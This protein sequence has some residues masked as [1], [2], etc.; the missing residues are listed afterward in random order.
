VEALLE[1]AGLSTRFRTFDG[2]VRAV[3]DVSFSLAQGEVLALVGESGCG[4]SVTAR[5]VMG[6]YK[7]SRTVQEG[8]IRFRGRELMGLPEAERIKYRGKEMS[9]IFQEPMAAFDPLATVGEQMV[10]ARLAHVLGSDKAS[11]AGHAAK[12]EA[13]ALAVEALRSVGIPDPGMRIDE[14]PHRLSGGMLQRVLIATALMNEPCL[15]IADEPT[16]ALD[17]TIQAQVL[18]LI[19]DL[20]EKNGMAVLFITHDLGVVAEVADRV[21]VM[22]SGSIVEKASVRELFS[23]DGGPLHPYAQGLLE[24][25]VRRDRKG[26]ELPSIPGSVPRP[27][28]LPPGCRFAP[29]CPKAGPRCGREVPKLAAVG[30]ETQSVACWLYQGGVE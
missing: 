15:L 6:L 9:M 23:R 8:S 24:S 18:R 20:K 2:E 10:D 26:Q 3:E 13:K 11:R 30:G 21:H 19:R 17:V 27:V 25:R 12:A 22:Y 28:D 4:K 16:T 14:Y 1:I 7:G 5:S 29:R